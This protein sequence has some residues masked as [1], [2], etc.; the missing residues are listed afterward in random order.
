MCQYEFF[1]GVDWGS[2]EHAVR[3]LSVDGRTNRKRCF[4]HGGKGLKEMVEWLEKN[5][6]GRL[7]L[8]AVGIETPRGAVVDILLER[9]A[10]VYGI[11]PKQLD[12][13]RDRYSPA[14]AKD[15]GLDAL[16]LADSLRT[17]MHCFRPE[18]RVARGS[19]GASAL[20]ERQG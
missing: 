10:G 6:G 11:N 2:V 3:F 5:S 1:A 17:D 8:V 14:G 16:V 12:R 20:P 18:S 7:A 19:T 15:D 13:F 4:E 9:G